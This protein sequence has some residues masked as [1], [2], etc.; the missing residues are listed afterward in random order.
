MEMERSLRKRRP[1]DRPKV[2]SN[3][4]IFTLCI[5]LAHMS[6]HHMLAECPQRPKKGTGY[7]APGNV[8]GFKSS[9]RLWE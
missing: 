3:L 2:R 4:L 1:S 8:N 6:V 7:L 5:L 9:Y